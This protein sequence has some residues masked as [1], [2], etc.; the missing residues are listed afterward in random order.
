VLSEDEQAKLKEKFFHDMLEL[1]TNIELISRTFPESV[2]EVI[3]GT[4]ILI[5]LT[6]LYCLVLRKS[7]K[8]ISTDPRTTYLKP[9]AKTI[10]KLSLKATESILQRAVLPKIGEHTTNYGA[11]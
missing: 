8:W 10:L 3:R 1:A 2:L 4:S 11:V 6:N 7:R 9:F 5:Y